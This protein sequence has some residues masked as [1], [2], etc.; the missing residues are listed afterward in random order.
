MAARTI[1]QA[2]NLHDSL[3]TMRGFVSNIGGYMVDQSMAQ[4]DA[5]VRSSPY[6]YQTITPN[7]VAIEGTRNKVPTDSNG[8]P[9]PK[10]SIIPGVSNIVLLAVGVVALMVLRR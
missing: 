5:S 10:T 3:R 2:E 4:I 7:G 9:A 6:Q 8:N 1:Q